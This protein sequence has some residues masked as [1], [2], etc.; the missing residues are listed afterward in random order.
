MINGQAGW[1]HTNKEKL[2]LG[3]KAS[4]RNGERN[5]SGVKSHATKQEI[6]AYVFFFFR[7]KS[8]CDVIN[9]QG[10]NIP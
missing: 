6:K 1:F 4:P 5:G 7:M 10:G 8:P 2:K 9:G 3:F